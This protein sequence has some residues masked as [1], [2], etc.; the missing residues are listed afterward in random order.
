MRE[1]K[2]GLI[3]GRQTPCSWIST[4]KTSILNTKDY[5]VIYRLNIIPMKILANFLMAIEKLILKK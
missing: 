1:I 5:K 4:I 2:E 3:K